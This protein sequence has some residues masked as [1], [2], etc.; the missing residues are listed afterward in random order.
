MIEE[1][2]R[3]IHTF[4]RP[5]R[6]HNGKEA[7]HQ[8]CT[9]RGREVLLADCGP[10]SSLIVIDHLADTLHH[11]TIDRALQCAS[12]HDRLTSHV[13]DPLTGDMLVTTPLVEDRRSATDLHRYRE[14]D[15]SSHGRLHNDQ[16]LRTATLIRGLCRDHRLDVMS[17]GRIML[18]N[19][20]VDDR[21]P[22]AILVQRLAR[23]REGRHHQF[24]LTESAS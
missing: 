11:R 10:S 21:H 13:L 20:G 14:T 22:R 16:V 2:M 18:K 17:G 4:P 23:P 6:E 9:D 8:C 5:V 19:H 3:L 24:T 1:E 15:T 7:G 12:D